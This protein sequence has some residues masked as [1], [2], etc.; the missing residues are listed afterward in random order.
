MTPSDLITASLAKFSIFGSHGQLFLFFLGKKKM[1]KTICL[2]F[3]SNFIESIDYYDHILI[4]LVLVVGSVISQDMAGVRDG[5]PTPF[6]S[7]L[8]SV[9]SKET[10]LRLSTGS[11]SKL[12]RSGSL[13]SVPGYVSAVCPV[14]VV[15][16]PHLQDMLTI[17]QGT[18]T[19]HSVPL[20]GLFLLLVVSV[21][22]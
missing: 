18:C 22:E 5:C 8:V 17:A 4:V 11:Q 12:C 14:I 9:S 21:L 6:F 15:L 13:Q 2:D 16:K 3:M 20:A 1:G 19:L 10:H 7:Y